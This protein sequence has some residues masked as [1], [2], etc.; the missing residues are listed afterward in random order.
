MSI[1]LQVTTNWPGTLPA[2]ELLRSRAM[3]ANPGGIFL[4]MAGNPTAW[5]PAKYVDS[6]RKLEEN[7]TIKRR[8]AFIP[9]PE[10]IVELVLSA[11]SAN[12]E[13]GRLAFGLMLSSFQLQPVKPLPAVPATNSTPA[14]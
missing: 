14:P 2:D 10:G 6:V 9:C 8:H 3:A 7:I 5:R 4:L 13:K 11:N 1:T 12:F